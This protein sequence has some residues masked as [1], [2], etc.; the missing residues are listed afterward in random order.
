[1]EILQFIP[2]HR[3]IFIPAQD[4]S[5]LQGKLVQVSWSDQVFDMEKIR[6]DGA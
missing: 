1:M 2:L 4:M 6:K 3:S 5:K